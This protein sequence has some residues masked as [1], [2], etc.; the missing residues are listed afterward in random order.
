MGRRT[1][2]EDGFEWIALNN[3]PKGCYKHLVGIGDNISSG[4]RG[5]GSAFNISESTSGDHDVTWQF[6]QV[7]YLL[8]GMCDAY[9]QADGDTISFGVY[10]PSTAGSSNPGAGDFDKS[11]VAASKYRFQ[12]VAAGTGDWD[13]NISETL[14]ANVAFTKAVP[15]PNPYGTGY[16]NFNPTTGVMTTAPNG[17]GAY[18]IYDHDKEL[19]SFVYKIPVTDFMDLRDDGVVSTPVLPHYKYR[20][21][22]NR[23]IA[24]AFR[25]CWRLSLG[26][27]D[28]RTGFWG[29]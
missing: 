8:G 26:F 13:L 28:T 25:C 29:D 15:Y 18:D 16:F 11:L 1:R 27:Y 7:A 12:P 20:V 24:A 22:Y 5:G 23:T 9:D 19:S 6:L 17:D 10:A 3:L 2:A 21:R 14:N 4:V